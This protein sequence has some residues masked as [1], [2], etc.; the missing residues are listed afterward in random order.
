M[1]LLFSLSDGGFPSLGVYGKEEQ[2]RLRQ[3]RQNSAADGKEKPMIKVQDWI[4]SIPDEDKHVAY[5][6]EGSSETRE[7]LLC[8]YGWEAYKGWSF[9]LDMAFDPESI[10]TRDHRQVVQTRVNSTE[11]KEEAGV[12]T[13]EVTTRETYTVQDEQ[14]LDYYLTDVA[15]LVKRV[16]EDGIRLEWT[17]L[18]QHTMLPGKLWAT[19]RAVDS[20]A[21]KV[22]K[23]AVM[24]F[25][26]DAAVKATPAATPPV[27]EM[28][29]IEARASAAADTA[30]YGADRAEGA[31]KSVLN[32]KAICV[33]AAETAYDEA[34]SAAVSA[35]EASHHATSAEASLN[36]ARTYAS[37]AGTNAAAAARQATE[38]AAAQKTAVEAAETCSANAQLCEEMAEEATNAV[39]SLTCR[40]V[41]VRDCGAVGDGVADDRAAIIEAF[42]QA[43]TMLP[44]EVYF[45]AGVYGISNGITVE[46]AYGTGGLKVCGAGRD[47][48]VIR[49]L[50]SYDPNQKGNMWY[51]IRIWPVG[52]PSVKPSEEAEYLY[53][54]SVS[55]LT[56]HDPD[57]IA[58]AWN[59]AKGDPGKEETHGFDLQFC[60]RVSVTDCTIEGV[61][62]EAIDICYCHD[63]AVMNNHLLG[64]PGAGSAGGAISIGDGCTGV[65]VCG[66][67]INSSAA[68]ETLADGTVLHKRNFGIAVESL[69]VP[70]SDVVI[71]GNT[72]RNV[73]G[74]GVNVGATNAGSGIDN[75]SIHGNVITDCCN[76]IRVMDT[77]NPKR[78]LSIVNNTIVGCFGDL[79]SD[80]YAIQTGTKTYQLLVSGNNIRNVGGE[81]AMK[82]VVADH[83]LVTDN[84]V[85]DVHG[86][87]MMTSGDVEVRNSTFYNI[88]IG[89]SATQAIQKMDVA[90]NRLSLSGCR[91][92]NVHCSVGIRN[93]DV[94]EHTDVELSNGGTA[95]VGKYLSRVTGGRVNGIVVLSKA[96]AVMQGVTVEAEK[97]TNHAVTI[98]A[99]GVSV[100]GCRIYAGNAK[101][102]VMENS[103]VSGSMVANNVVDGTLSLAATLVLVNGAG[104]VCVNNIDLRTVTA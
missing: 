92:S 69:Y 15:P 101:K 60:R 72:I 11:M 79:S 47:V 57:P 98:A 97:A 23:S 40:R 50:D 32:E 89:G 30:T 36:A 29:Q 46:M 53:D 62:D 8:G 26:V 63:V 80:G 68:D 99:D 25:E 61:G 4:A 45:P 104:S 31:L 55:G 59:T 6:G 82:I 16:E 81:Q 70:V 10:T 52:M 3:R 13:D 84:L 12:T 102:A 44:C 78:N 54:M 48:T 56:V 22:K 39:K 14:V 91:L 43:K 33:A 20:T 42:R 95:L 87:A 73:R 7:F 28:A 76:G 37:A 86:Y 49:Y 64:C 103:G 93:A 38:A 88:G 96:G 94:V 74:N 5:V 71:A 18:R 65:V 51:A 58:H 21:Q 83:A 2:G 100:T 24:V 67:T 9:H 85:G 75:V 19:L 17:V 1:R 66:N 27:S 90:S 34:Q 41:N 77:T 35:A